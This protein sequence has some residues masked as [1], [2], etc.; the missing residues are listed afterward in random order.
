MC[1]QSTYPLNNNIFVFYNRQAG[2]NNGLLNRSG[3][4]IFNESPSI[5]FRPDN[6]ELELR[7]NYS[8]QRTTNSIENINTPTVHRYGGRFDGSYYAPFGLVLATDVNYQAT[9]GYSQGYNTNTWMW[10]ASISYQFMA[11][12]AATV[13]LKV[14]DLLQ[15]KSSIRRSVTANYI[16]DSETNALGRYVMVTLAYKF[17]TFGAGNIPQSRNDYGGPP[18]PPAGAPRPPRRM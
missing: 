6:L 10:N 13:M 2:Y 9:K 14:Y 17:N 12:R 3:T 16:D 5:A 4:L 1:P 8:M 18:A 7:P 15:Q 11:G